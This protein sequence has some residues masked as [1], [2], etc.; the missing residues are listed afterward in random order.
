MDFF[1]FFISYDISKRLSKVESLCCALQDEEHI[2]GCGV[3]G[4]L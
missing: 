2:M 3:A 1:E 4:G